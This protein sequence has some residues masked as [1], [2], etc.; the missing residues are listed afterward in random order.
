FGQQLIILRNG[1]DDQGV[2]GFIR[3]DGD[4]AFASSGRY[5]AAALS[6]RWLGGGRGWGRASVACGGARARGGR[7]AGGRHDLLCLRSQDLGDILGDGILQV[8][9]V[10]LGASGR[11][12][13]V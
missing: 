3:G 5:H 6:R 7:S 10:E 1:G 12:F 13:D 4:L 11:E 9:D 2:G 8:I